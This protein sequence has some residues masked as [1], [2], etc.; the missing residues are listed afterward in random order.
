[1]RL[2]WEALKKELCSRQRP[3]LRDSTYNKLFHMIQKLYFFNK[4]ISIT[5][6]EH[7]KKKYL[8]ARISKRRDADNGIQSVP[9]IF[10]SHQSLDLSGAEIF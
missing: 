10:H 4:S 8:R 9:H 6:E 7:P 1:M 2:S 3:V 5:V